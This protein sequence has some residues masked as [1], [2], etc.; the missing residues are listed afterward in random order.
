MFIKKIA[1]TCSKEKV[2]KGKWSF[3]IIQ[4]AGVLDG[5]ILRS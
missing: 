3:H 2:L 5:K 1:N 4:A